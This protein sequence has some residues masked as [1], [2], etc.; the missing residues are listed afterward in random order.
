MIEGQRTAGL[1]QI[2]DE[3]KKLEEGWSATPSRLYELSCY[4]TERRPLLDAKSQ[5][6]EA[7]KTSN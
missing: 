7:P 2:M 4:L 3:R 1:Q 5:T 6:D